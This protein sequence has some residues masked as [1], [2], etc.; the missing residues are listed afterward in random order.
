MHGLWEKQRR[1]CGEGMEGTDVPVGCGIREGTD[2]ST[3]FW[4]LAS[5]RLLLLLMPSRRGKITGM[6]SGYSVVG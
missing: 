4:R 2:N 6:T 3:V 5:V 1:V